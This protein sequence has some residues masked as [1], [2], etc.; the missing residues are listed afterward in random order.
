MK[1][2]FGC[3]YLTN[4]T[5]LGYLSLRPPVGIRADG[6]CP[7]AR[8]EGVAVAEPARPLLRVNGCDV[9]VGEVE[10]RSRELAH[11]LRAA[12]GATGPVVLLHHRGADAALLT[13]ACYR[14]GLVVA[15]VDP[16]AP[17]GYLTSVLETVGPRLIVG[18]HDHLD[19]VAPLFEGA[20]TFAIDDPWTENP[21]LDGP[22]NTD[23]E[24][25]V[26]RLLPSPDRSSPALLVFSSGTTGN[27]KAVVHSLATLTEV[28]HGIVSS[29]GVTPDDRFGDLSSFQFIAAHTTLIVCLLTTSSMA[30]GDVATI[31]LER[32]GS[33]LTEASVTILRAQVSL[34]RSIANSSDLTSTAIRLVTLAGESVFGE[35]LLRLRKRLPSGATLQCRYG[36]TEAQGLLTATFGP[37]DPIGPGAIRFCMD[38]AVALMDGELN[39]VGEP[40]AGFEGQLVASRRL[41]VGYWKRPKAT[42]DSFVEIGG[43]RSFRTGDRA[44]AVGDGT[45]EVLGRNDSR[46]KIRGHNVDLG[47]VEAALAQHE[48]LRAC[49]VVDRRSAN[50]AVA[51]VA[52]FIPTAGKLPGTRALREFLRETLPEHMIPARF[53]PLGGFPTTIAGKIDRQALRDRNDGGARQVDDADQGQDAGGGSSNDRRIVPRDQLTRSLIEHVSVLLGLSEIGDHDDFFDLGMDSLSAL[54]LV[55]WIAHRFGVEIRVADLVRHSTITRLLTVVVQRQTTNKRRLVF[56]VAGDAS[57]RQAAVFIPGAGD[58]I[59]AML[60]LARRIGRHGEVFVVQSPGVERGAEPMRSVEKFSERIVSELRH[61]GVFDR[62]SLVIGGHS[63]GGIVAHE[64]ARQIEQAGRTVDRVV[65]LDTSPPGPLANAD[66]LRVFHRKIEAWKVDHADRKR[67]KQLANNDHQR[68]DLRV[69]KGIVH[70]QSLRLLHSHRARTCSARILVVAA[71]NSHHDHR[72]W[73]VEWGRLTSG[74]VEVVS[75]PGTHADLH[76]EAHVDSLASLLGEMWSSCTGLRNQ[77]PGVIVEV[78][79]DVVPE[80]APVAMLAAQR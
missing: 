63:F 70:N 23:A 79:Q 16:S 33:W 73:S 8:L 28:A 27:P 80:L 64:V 65:V 78:V 3:G 45:V 21:L 62:K 50:G 67:A 22:G 37:N 51:L 68:D 2:P 60:G 53:V 4:M 31:G 19:A 54:E 20:L 72:S 36:S 32:L 46:V 47:T 43:V 24:T 66:A 44:V 14:A 34:A 57:A 55:A 10:R 29:L 35:D 56:S 9:G 18:S 6:L 59:V 11:Q 38:D 69:R 71:D 40:S 58:S 41:A 15:V 74:G 25:L 17:A 48:Q 52:F 5:E 12:C 49:V 26:D 7:L 30:S 77:S 39:P 13:L 1:N 76:A 61:L 75:T 42:A